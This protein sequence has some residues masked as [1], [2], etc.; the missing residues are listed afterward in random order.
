[1]IYRVAINKKYQYIKVYRILKK[2]GGKES[3]ISKEFSKIVDKFFNK[4]KPVGSL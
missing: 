4:N 1:M 3:G 2:V